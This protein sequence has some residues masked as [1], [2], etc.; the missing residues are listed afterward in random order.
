[1]RCVLRC[2]SY[3]IYYYAYDADKSCRLDCPLSTMRDHM[4]QKCVSSCPL[5]TFF[6]TKFDACV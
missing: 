4:T 3:P 5:N 1:M 2:P 6:D